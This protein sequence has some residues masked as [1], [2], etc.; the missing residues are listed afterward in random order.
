MF[1]THTHTSSEGYSG[2]GGKDGLGTYSG[3][4]KRG[5]SRRG[6]G[7]LAIFKLKDLS[8]SMRVRWGCGT[9]SLRRTHSALERKIKASAGAGAAMAGQLAL[10][11]PPSLALSSTPAAFVLQLHSRHRASPRGPSGA[12]LDIA[13]R[14][15]Q[16]FAEEWEPGWVYR[17][18][19]SQSSVQQRFQVG[20]WPLLRLV[21]VGGDIQ[22]YQCLVVLQGDTALALGSTSCPV[23]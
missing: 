21:V 6:I 5:G 20:P 9:G 17:H 18:L 11:S 14:R 13:D 19:L 8:K 1:H 23:C 12:L 3:I 15:R 7:H 10:G 16:V 2:G 22:H 4:G